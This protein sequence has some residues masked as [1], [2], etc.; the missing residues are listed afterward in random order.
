MNDWYLPDKCSSMELVYLV[1]V[2]STTFGAVVD[3][4]VEH[5]MEFVA[6]DD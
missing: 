4:I 1:H 3:D 5:S 6:Y 2:L